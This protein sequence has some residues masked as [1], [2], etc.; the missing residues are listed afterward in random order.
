MCECYLD[1][2]VIPSADM[3]EE[4][5]F[6]D[7]KN[8]S[9]IHA[10]IDTT[11]AIDEEAKENIGK[12]MIAT[13][14]PYRLQDAYNRDRHEK[15]Y[16]SVVLENQY[17]KARF[18]P[19]LGGRLW[20]LYDKIAGKE[21]LYCNPVFQPGNLALRNAWFS[22]GVEFNVSVKGHNPLTC[23][24]MF[25]R[26]IVLEDGS[27]GVR[28]YEYERIRGVAYSIDAWL[29]EDKPMLYIRPRIE[30]RTSKKIWMYW[31]SNIAVPN[32]ERTRVIVPTDKTFINHFG[33]DHYLLDMADMPYTMDT[34]ISY[35]KNL[36]QSLDFFYKIP[37]PE[38]KWI[39]AL[40]GAGYGLLQ[41]STKHLK[42][43]KLFVWGEGSGG[44]NWSRHLSNGENSGYIEIQAGLAYTQL[45]HIPM[46]D[47]EVWS[48]VEGYGSLQC[49]PDKVHGTWAGARRCVEK[50]I[51]DKYWQESFQGVHAELETKLLM[52][53]TQQEYFTYGSG[54]GTLEEYRRMADGE[55]A[56][57][58]NLEFPTSALDVNQL[59]WLQLL[60]KGQLIMPEK[61]TLPKGYLVGDVWRKRLEK[62]V[63]EGISD[64]WYGWL[65]LGVM[66]YADGAV[67]K[68]RECFEKSIEDMP[69]VCAYRNLSML[70]RNEYLNAEKAVEYMDKAVEMN[71]DCRALMVDAAVTYMAAGQAEKWIALFETLSDS[72]QRDGRLQFFYTVS[73][74]HQ[75]RYEE[76]A[77]ILNDRL[78]FPDVKEGDTALSDVWQELYRNILAK[79]TGETNIEKLNEMVEREYPL[80]NLDFRTH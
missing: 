58:D 57:S 31:W 33:N 75:E 32:E 63:K 21:L 60:Q 61:G 10:A 55:K 18:L 12:G 48:W 56:L 44:K 72:L 28:L 59:E 15:V 22:G 77:E 16:T 53:A 24:P 25:S 79:R 39:C 29:V 26:K 68:A 8:V 23:S 67:E 66:E 14:L 50:E 71:R 65:Q 43:R 78:V 37:M 20:S 19:E 70:W 36:K 3:G 52:N 45:E 40:D 5:P 30:N 38:E 46:E 11:E 73:L 76:A 47:G 7:I 49:E 51:N 62:T 1:P 35:P 34:D 54:W 27:Q 13:M 42:G 17:L 6:P 74:M 69:N 80:G 9:Y 4:N 64:H 2:F 41:C